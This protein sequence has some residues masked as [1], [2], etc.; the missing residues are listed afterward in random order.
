MMKKL[1][2]AVAILILVCTVADAKFT[3]KG[4]IIHEFPTDNDYIE[5]YSKN[6]TK[7]NIYY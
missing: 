3:P 6:L 2:I 1:I 4:V 5:V 7:A